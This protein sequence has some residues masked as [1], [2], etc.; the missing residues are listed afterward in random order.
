MVIAVGYRNRFGHPNA[1][2]LERLGA[3][4]FRTDRDGAITVALAGGTVE[5]AGER[6]RRRRYWHDAPS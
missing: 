2:V 4:V 5:I 6:R 3:P 1:G